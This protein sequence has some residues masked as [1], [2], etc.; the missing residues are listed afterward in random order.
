MGKFSMGQVATYGPV[1]TWYT[2]YTYL[3][4]ILGWII[5]LFRR[6]GSQFSF[7]LVQAGGCDHFLGQ[8]IPSIHHSVAEEMFPDVSSAVCFLDLQGVTSE[9]TLWKFEKFIRWCFI[10][11]VYIFVHFNEVCSLSPV[12]QGFKSDIVIT[13]FFT[14]GLKF[15]Q[16]FVGDR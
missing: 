15:I 12:T 1:C 3:L 14:A 13:H 8:A 4:G 5:P 6:K 2:W 10:E 9:W 7:K 16:K 11:P